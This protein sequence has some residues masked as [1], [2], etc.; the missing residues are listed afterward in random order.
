MPRTKPVPVKSKQP[1]R[2]MDQLEV[3]VDEA[4]EVCFQLFPKYYKFVFRV[5]WMTRKC[6]ILEQNSNKFD[7]AKQSRFK[8][9]VEYVRTEEDT[10]DDL[11][12]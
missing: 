11:Y 10:V 8:N 5:F 7:A 4:N 12:Q 3:E 2:R 6:K 9:S 1:A